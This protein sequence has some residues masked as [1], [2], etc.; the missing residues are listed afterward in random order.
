MSKRK[1][2]TLIELLVVIAI[3]AVLMSILMPALSRAKGGAKEAVCKNHQHQ[4][5]L[6]WKMFTDDNEGFF[7]DRD[8][9]NDW[10]VMIKDGYETALDPKIWLCPMATKNSDFKTIRPE[11]GRNPFAAWDDSMGGDYY[12]GSYVINLYIAAAAQGSRAN[13]A[14][15]WG[16]PSFKGAAYG[17]IMFDGQWKD[18]E[19]EGPWDEPPEDEQDPWNSG[20][21]HEMRRACIKRHGKYNVFGTFLDF[22]CRKKTIKEIWRVRW[23]KNWPANADLPVWPAWM[24]DVPEPD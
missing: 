20:P 10:L 2:F 13:W 6:I 3:I 17:P 15:F 12:K 8:A 22:S 24:A 14:D 9:V 21:K 1:G 23:H 16:T 7:M 11:G 4:W 19:S 18:M 5:G